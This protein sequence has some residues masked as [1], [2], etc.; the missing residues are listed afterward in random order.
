M[1]SNA[2][3]GKTK[4]AGNASLE[5]ARNHNAAMVPSDI[6]GVNSRLKLDFR[7]SPDVIFAVGVGII[8]IYYAGW[9]VVKLV[10]LLVAAISAA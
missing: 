3:A 10:Q 7:R 8:A 9:G 1:N 2:E 5:P 4:L 6:L